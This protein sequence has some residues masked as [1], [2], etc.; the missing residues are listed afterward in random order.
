MS[1]DSSY[2]RRAFMAYFTSIGLGSTLLPGVLWAQANQQ[3]AHC[4][5]HHK[6]LKTSVF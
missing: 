6:S 1:I 3:V 4:T 2:D 5:A